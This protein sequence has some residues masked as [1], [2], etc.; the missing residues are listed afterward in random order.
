MTREEAIKSIVDAFRLTNEKQEGKSFYIKED[1]DC[2]TFYFDK[3]EYLRDEV[4][5]GLVRLLN[6]VNIVDGQCRIE[7]LTLV[8]TVAHI[9]K[10]A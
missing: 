4:I 5:R 7:P 3:R 1:D 8:W 6:D 9:E 2:A 10:R